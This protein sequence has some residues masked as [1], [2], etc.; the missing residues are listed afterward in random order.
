MQKLDIIYLADNKEFIQTCASWA[1]GQ[2]GCQSGGTLDRAI[3]KFTK[4]AN[5]VS[6]PITLLALYDTK[7]AGMIS[8]WESDFDGKLEL[9]PW[10]ASLYVHPFYRH[11]NIASCLIK[12]LESRASQ[13]GYSNLFLV[14]EEAKNLYVKYGWTEIEKV[15]TAYGKASLM[16]KSLNKKTLIRII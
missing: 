10:L 3:E 6:L 1:Y 13:L 4:G 14:T 11:K 7:P 12:E 8:L 15:N 9:S 2:W 16:M 5:K